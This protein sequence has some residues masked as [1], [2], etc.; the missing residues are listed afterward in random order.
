MGRAFGINEKQPLKRNARAREGRRIKLA[1]RRDADGP[2][3]LGHPLEQGQDQS[4]LAD[5]GMGDEDFGECADRPAFA[6]QHGIQGGMAGGNAGCC[7]GNLIATPHKMLQ[8][9]WG[10]K[11]RNSRRRHG[12]K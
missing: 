6:G 8:R 5:T 9:V 7:R 3:P 4:E 12:N 2:A 10:T 11:G 1:R